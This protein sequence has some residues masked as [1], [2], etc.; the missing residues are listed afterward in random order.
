MSIDK[1][2]SGEPFQVNR[3]KKGVS[4]RAFSRQGLSS[5]ADPET[6]FLKRLVL[7]RLF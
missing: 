3:F 7:K 4:G 5:T 2:V 1:T 6:L